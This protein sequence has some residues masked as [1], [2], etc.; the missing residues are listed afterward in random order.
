M[1]RFPLPRVPAR[2]AQRG[3]IL[4]TSMLLLMVLTVLGITMMKT[5]NMQERMAGSTRDMA[6]ALQASEAALRNGERLINPFIVRRAPTASGAAGCLVCGVGTLP[7]TLDVPGDFDWD[8]NGR[9][10]GV[11]GTQ[12]F[13]DLAQDPR[14]VIEEMLFVADSEVRTQDY[15]I[16]GR[17]F[18]QVSARST[19]ISGK[20]NVVLQST[21]ARPRS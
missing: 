4:V 6:V 14:Y 20:T 13:E 10:Y 9:E 19:G 12:E 7:L 15:G 8:A 11:A 16:D 21:Y 3:A 2:S 18:Y 5:A 1:N 17:D